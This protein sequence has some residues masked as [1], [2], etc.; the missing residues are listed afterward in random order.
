GSEAFRA[1]AM[2]EGGGPPSAAR[3]ATC[4]VAWTPVSVRPATARPSHV[5]NAASNA[6]RRT[7]S[8]VLRPGWRAQP[9]N[10]LPSYSSVSLSRT[11]AVGRL[12]RE[13]QAVDGANDDGRARVAAA[14][15]ARAPDLAVHPYLPVRS[16]LGD[17]DRRLADQGLDPDRGPLASLVP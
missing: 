11:S 13:R 1:A 6:S 14:I 5:G 4:P 15:A 16:K 9:W 12:D 10:P 17:C 8:T 3:L 7:P 2:L